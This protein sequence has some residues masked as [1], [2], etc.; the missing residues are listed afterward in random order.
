MR[1][2]FFLSGD[3]PEFGYW[4]VKNLISSYSKAVELLRDG[5]IVV[6]ESENLPSEFFRRLAL[7]RESFE[8]L[9]SVEVDALESAFRDVDVSRGVCEGI[10]V[11]VK[12]IK[13]QTDVKSTE[14]ERKLG[15]ILWRRGLKINL[16]SP[17]L[18][19]RVYV[20]EK[21][22]VGILLHVTETKQFLERRPDRRPFFKPGALLPRLAR[23]L[24][25][26][27]GIRD[28]VLVDP[29]CG[30]GT[31]LIEAGLMGLEFVGVEAY[32]WVA[33]GCLKNL[34]HYDLPLNL[35]RGDVKRIP[36]SDESITAIVTDYPYLRS[37][38]SLGDLKSLYERSL[39]EFHRV[40]G[41][42]GSAVLVSN[43]D[44]E[45]FNGFDNFILETKLTQRVHKNL[46]R[47]VFVLRKLV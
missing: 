14:L 45:R 32:K 24:V 39:E 44:I 33:E 19:F 2:G 13:R 29:M 20:G 42:N 27:S 46:Q 12:K 7:V 21:C 30:T 8:Y 47:K 37:S 1:Y 15:G 23:S 40:L 28:G 16:S 9:F 6:F 11:R 26:I 35:I 18:T 41:K 4:E 5:R 3:L 17:D 43:Q 10:C 25:N 36:M 38:K 31:I 34:R 22:H